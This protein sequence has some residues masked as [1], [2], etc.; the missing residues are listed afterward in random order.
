M[1]SHP[2][3]KDRI[4]VFSV[5]PVLATDV[6]E[7]LSS[8]PDTRDYEVSGTESG[9]LSDSIS[10]IERTSRDS[11]SARVLILDVRSHTLP[12]LQHAYNKILG[13]NRWDLNRSCYTILIGDGPR[14]LFDAGKS[15]SV[16]APYLA[17]H[18]QDYQPAAFF[19]DPLLHYT[20]DERA[21]AG[22]RWGDE[23]PENIPRRLAMELGQ[24]D[25][26]VAAARRYFRAASVSG[27]N[28]SK[29]MDQRQRLL[30]RLFEHTIAREFPHH[31]DVRQSWLCKEGY[32]M[33]GEVLRLL[34]YPFF[35]EEW[36]FELM[37]KAKEP[38]F[39]CVRP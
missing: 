9:Q 21:A 24:D 28:K 2:D 35:F 18:R 29:V 30:A 15:L 22:I 33:G 38:A 8:H 37:Q 4:C 3:R 13:Y 25:M 23:L 11:V 7:R 20:S 5:D 26:P 14:D 10:T 16:L 17:R 12:R 1:L 36:V 39:K 34:A 19:F 6:H 31:G 32:T 27:D